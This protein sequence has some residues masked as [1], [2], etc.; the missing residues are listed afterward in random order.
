[1]RFF[2]NDE[3]VIIISNDSTDL[4]GRTSSVGVM[5]LHSVVPPA[6]DDTISP[7]IKRLNLIEMPSSSLIYDDQEHHLESIQTCQRNDN[8]IGA[9]LNIAA[10]Y[11]R[12]SCERIRS[13]ASFDFPT[14]IGRPNLTSGLVY[15]KDSFEGDGPLKEWVIPSKPDKPQGKFVVAIKNS[16]TSQETLTDSTP[17]YIVFGPDICGLQTRIVHVI[18]NHNDTNYNCKSSPKCKDDVFTHVHTLHLYA[19][20]RSYEV[21]IDNESLQAEYLTD[22]WPILQPRE[23]AYLSYAKPSYRDDREWIADP[24]DQIPDNWQLPELIEDIEATKPDDWDDEADGDWSAPMKT[25]PA[26]MGKLVPLTI[27]NLDYR[28]P[29]IAKQIPNPEYV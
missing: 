4:S 13:P 7:S 5:P 11:I 16:G 27:D 23:I 6:C 22:D 3:P 17:Y 28:G 26:Y 21:M 18:I 9:G 12:H 2:S 8:G 1:M 15:F 14:S 25:N 24:N 29:W 20:N 10:P 19:S